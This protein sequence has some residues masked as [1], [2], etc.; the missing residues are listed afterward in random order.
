MD[1]RKVFS[2]LLIV[3]FLSG[4]SGATGQNRSSEE[5]HQESPGWIMATGLGTAGP[6]LNIGY[7]AKRS[8]LFRVGFEYV[9]LK[10]GFTFEENDINYEADLL[11]RTGNVSLLAD[12]YFA[13]PLFVTAGAGY[14]LFRPGIDGRAAGQW[15]YGDIYIPA[16]DIGEFRFNVE[17]SWN[18]TPY[19]GVGIGR[20]F[21]KM[22]Q[23]SAFSEIGAYYLGPPRIN[24]EATG[25]L[26]PTADE[27]HQHASSL[28]KHF[29]SWRYY[30][31]VRAGLSI[32]LT[33]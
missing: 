29:S 13:G 15:K 6:G 8:L 20:K 32:L 18:I 14:N 1:E 26:S 12:Y 16:E 24:V 10:Y 27:A 33:K 9:N 7:F 11:L 19:F 21:R 17:P 30:P 28:E 25:L 31:V 2:F 23:V 3:L 5:I 4:T 22:R